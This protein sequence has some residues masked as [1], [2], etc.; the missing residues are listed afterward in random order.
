[1]PQNK[2]NPSVGPRTRMILAA[3]GLTISEAARHSRRLFPH[4]PRFHIPPNLY[5][6]LLH[7]GFSPSIQ[8]LFVLSQLSGYR[9]VDWL[10]IFGVV[11]DDIPLLQATLPARYTTLIDANVYDEQVPGL[12]FEVVGPGIPDGSLR[13]LGEWLRVG[14]AGWGTAS[15]QTRKSD[16]LYA[17]I[18]CLDALAF[19]ELLPGSIVR[20]V[21]QSS[22]SISVPLGRNSFFL[23]EHAQGLA[24]CRL[25]PV[26]PHRVVLCP[27]YLPFAHVELALDQQVR[28]L[29][30]VDFELRPTAGPTHPRVSRSLAHSL[31]LPDLEEPSTESRLDALLRR[32]RRRSGLTFREASAKSALIARVLKNEEFFC[33]AGSLSDYET[34][35][36]GPRHLRKMFSL[37]TLYSIDAWEFMTAAG[38]DT[39]QAGKDPMPDAMRGRVTLH[40]V[41]NP[42]GRETDSPPKRGPVSIEFPHVF[43]TA[44]ARLFQ[45]PH[46]SIRDIFWI[47]GAR[48]SFHPFLA[49]AAAIVVDRRKKRIRWHPS[50]P[51]WAQPSYVLLGRDGRYV[52]TSCSAD[53]KTLVMRPFSNGF[54]R[55]VRLSRP[56]EVEV[57]GTVVGILRNLSET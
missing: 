56:N 12:P 6:T 28:I 7:R 23:V 3:R 17:K 51:L 19:P 37:C 38:I 33:A 8:Q 18:G 54:D 20:I 1:M 30:V 49:A 26:E 41:D 42:S 4:D 48:K 39:S 36:Q 27:V 5:H 47:G 40:N 34:T 14:A 32:A 31:S 22:V 13:P 25:H 35:T 15:P 52:C 50:G 46:L 11:L 21:K 45:M 55:P 2:S 16:F 44:A 57:I 29:G 9:L 24:C 43:A 53:G 10:A